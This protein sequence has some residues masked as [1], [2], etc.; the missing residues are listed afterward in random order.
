[1][2]RNLLLG[3][4]FSEKRVAMRNRT[5]EITVEKP[6]NRKSPMSVTA[7]RRRTVGTVNQLVLKVARL[8]RMIKYTKRTLSNKEVISSIIKLTVFVIWQIS[9]W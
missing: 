5:M 9:F 8:Y 6:G 4:I 1:M 3:D 7:N 2:A